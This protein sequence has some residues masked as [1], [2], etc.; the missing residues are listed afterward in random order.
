M[1]LLIWL[2]RHPLRAQRWMLLALSLF[3]LYAL[4]ATRSRLG[5]I[6]FVVTAPLCIF[7]LY[8]R[9]RL[10]GT[11]VSAAVVWTLGAGIWSILP[12][13][14]FRELLRMGEAD[15]MLK[16]RV[17]GRW[18]VIWERACE[19]PLMGWGYG[20]VRYGHIAGKIDWKF[21]DGRMDQIV[22]HNEHLGLFHDL[23][24]GAVLLFWIYLGSVLAGGIR[25]L[26]LPSGPLRDLLLALWLSWLVDGLNTMSH[27]GLL[28]VGNPGAPLFWIKGVLV[29]D[30]GR[31]VEAGL[32]HLR[33]RAIRPEGPLP[34][35]AHPSRG[36]P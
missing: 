31:M 32:R 15:E 23:G 17:E 35:L 27:D 13:D 30:G 14:N 16:T 6:A 9:Q 26:A 34:A 21:E 33:G 28:T 7:A 19:R 10:A 1:P 20:T 22:T 2:A 5:I 36:V 11:L 29:C 8:F 12:T 18:D 4:V 3:L 24:A 25:L